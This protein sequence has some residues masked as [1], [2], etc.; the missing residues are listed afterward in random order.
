M[1][2][3]PR[4]LAVALLATLPTVV[5][6]AQRPITLPADESWV[7][8][9]WD[10][11][12]G[13]PQ[14]TVSRVLQAR[15]GMLWVATYGGLCRF[16]GVR[17][18]VLDLAAAP[19]G[20]DS[21]VMALA[22]AS[23]GSIWF[24]TEMGFVGRVEAGVVQR[25]ARLGAQ[26]VVHLTPLADGRMLC[27][28]EA[29]LFVVAPD[30]S[31]APWWSE[32][33]PDTERC[34]L[35]PNG[36]ALLV[37]RYGIDL[38]QG[39]VRRQLH[40]G[41]MRDAAVAPDGSVWLA[42]AAG[43]LRW[44]G[45]RLEPVALPPALANRRLLSVHV[46]RRGEVWF[47][48]DTAL[49]RL[50]PGGGGAGSVYPTAT[51]P[52]CITG[53][54]SGG[55]WVGTLGSGLLRL[56]AGEATGVALGKPAAAVAAM[57]VAG[58]DTPDQ[59]LATS[60]RG[61]FRLGGKVASREP[62]VPFGSLHAVHRD[63]DGTL[64]LGALNGVAR[65]RGDACEL[66]AAPHPCGTVRAIVRDARGVLLAGA[67]D[68]VYAAE[69]GWTPYAPAAA[70]R[71]GWIKLLQPWH[72]GGMWIVGQ[73]A[74]LRLDG[75]LRPVGLWRRGEEL[76]VAEVRAI[77]R[78][79]GSRVWLATYG[80][81][82]VGLDGDQIRVVGQEAGLVDSFLCSAAPFA[83][84]WLVGGNRGP[85]LIAPSE[86]ERAADGHGSRI[87]VRRLACPTDSI[88]TE[89]IGGA[90]AGIAV[91]GDTAAICSIGGV[92][93][94]RGDSLR[95]EV[96]APV[97]HLQPLLRGDQQRVGGPASMR[98]ELQSARTLVVACTA[99]E[100]EDP[101][102]L[103]FAWR[104]AGGAWS[105]PSLHRTL[106][107]VLPGAGEFTVEFRAIDALGNPGPATTLVALVQPQW[108]EVT[109]L[110]VAVTGGLLL[111][112]GMLF[113]GGSRRSA[114]RA[115]ELQQ[116]VEART[117]ELT[118]ARDQLELRVAQ[119]TDELQR[120]L[121]SREREHSERARLGRQLEQLRRMESLGQLAGSV[122]HD[123]NNLLTVVLGNA[124]LIEADAEDR[125]D[126]R[127]LA[128]RIQDAAV[129]GRDMTQR[130]LAVASR[131]TVVPRRLELGA[132]LRAQQEVVR[133]LMGPAIRVELTIVDEPLWVLAAAGQIDQIIFNL[134]VNARD[135][136][137]GG[138][139]FVLSAGRA[140]DPQL[141]QLVV[142]DS[143]VG[144]TAE[145]RARAF[146]PFFTTRQDV[147][148]GLGLATV[149]G[150]TKQLQ[151]EVEI[152]S[153][154]GRGTTFT[155]RLPAASAASAE[156][157]AAEP[158]VPIVR[159]EPGAPP[160]MGP[161]V[162]L[163]DDEADVRGAVRRLLVAWG[164]TVVA[165]VDS[166]AAAVVAVA[167]T[168]L[169]VD[170]VLTDVRMPGLHGLALVQALRQVRPGLPI[171]FVSG[172]ASSSELLS[173]LGPLG[174]E[175]VGKPPRRSE[176]LPALQ[177]AVASVPSR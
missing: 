110:W 108:W 12:S 85:F 131:Q 73:H 157:A 129:R 75:E 116:L 41:A 69:S 44:A 68:G 121:A 54:A 124:E 104:F 90:M 59:F 142:Q 165:E 132:V 56:S 83:G 22:V 158:A 87:R 101:S 171:V 153:A 118:L 46:S 145:V 100:F 115:A 7:V 80:S 88:A 51:S 76:P 43:L 126:T 35:L 163:V 24:G 135:A 151:G 99:P 49:G 10:T 112:G 27:G 148:T 174:I 21:R 38:V 114:R 161:R 70:L 71:G 84:Q 14:S 102:G 33:L 58:G 156:P 134:A 97:C 136:M 177:R 166:G 63:G 5:G 95:R 61:L 45:E 62:A 18:Q 143:G 140:A 168:T 176:V 67:D 164:C 72:D 3:S 39:A 107:A 117:Q 98:L 34:V 57:A 11:A 93:L 92:W 29:D 82:F 77:L 40:R 170:V 52:L 30:G 31:V 66:L 60:P 19:A 106:S 122:A 123:F 146:E 20:C 162:L 128:R 74:L 91:N 23:D 160:A 139:T 26:F 17:W 141:V 9:A 111:A 15:D 119:R 50:A 6:V 169:P 86:L 113:R 79:A 175:L 48:T 172:H 154:P 127:D 94:V 109:A 78:G 137:P 16:D 1:N 167:E 138:G 152:D 144:M 47:G 105:E 65:L 64:W 37:A 130:L 149:Y 8:R 13:L 55:I 96:P 42:G 120:A 147:G 4:R 53:D 25:V 36:D 89:A 159:P 173:Q 133:D 155:F 81:G 150:I 2:R 103:S 125:R 32:P 28:T